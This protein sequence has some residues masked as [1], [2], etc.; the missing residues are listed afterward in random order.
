[1][2]RS[3]YISFIYIVPWCIYHRIY[4]HTHIFQ[5][6]IQDFAKGGAAFLKSLCWM[7]VH[8]DLNRIQ[9]VLDW[10]VWRTWRYDGMTVH[11][12]NNNSAPCSYIMVLNSNYAHVYEH[13]EMLIFIV[14]VF[15]WVHRLTCWPMGQHTWLTCSVGLYKVTVDCYALYTLSFIH[16]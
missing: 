3:T 10:N 6:Q 2:K 14:C 1:M 12:I 16:T 11:Q 15:F 8:I 7:Y 13:N 5:L 4:L 9:S